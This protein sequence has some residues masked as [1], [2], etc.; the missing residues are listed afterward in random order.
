MVLRYIG[1]Q[2]IGQIG[3]QLILQMRHLTLRKFY[4]NYY[5]FI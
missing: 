5:E 2:L 1:G 4:F 3:E